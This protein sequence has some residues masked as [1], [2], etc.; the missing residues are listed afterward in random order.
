MVDRRRL[1]RM[2]QTA[3]PWFL[4]VDLQ[5]SL[6]GWSATM[7]IDPNMAK[8]RADQ[9]GL[10]DQSLRAAVRDERVRQVWEAH[11]ARVN[12]SL[13]AGQ[14]IVSYSLSNA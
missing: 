10:Q 11:I 1:A 6:G 8:A 13:P 9:Q 14:R 2:L 7:Q 5:P 4:K 3:S 12:T